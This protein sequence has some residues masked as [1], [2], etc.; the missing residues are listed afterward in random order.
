MKAITE[1][2]TSITLLDKNEIKRGGEGKILTIPELPDQVAKVYLNPNTS[3]LSIA[4]KEALS[5]LDTNYFVKPLELIYSDNK[6]K[7]EI[8]GFTMDFIPDD[9]V[10]LMV[11][12][13]KNFCVSNNIDYDFKTKLATRLI[14]ILEGAHQSDI[15]IGDLSGLNILVNMQ[16]AV[17]FLDVDS[18][19]TPVHTHSSV[20]FDEIR[21]YLYNGKVSKESDYFAL[22]I[23]IF[24]IFCHLHPFKGVHKIYKSIAERMINKIPVFVSDPDLI[25]PKCYEPIQEKMVQV[26]FEELFLEGKRF[27][28]KLQTIQT[29]QATQTKVILN[30]LQ[31]DQLILKELYTLDKGEVIQKSFFNTE[32]G[33]IA[34]NHKYMLWKVQAKGFADK[35]L[36]IPRG[37]FDHIFLGLKNIVATKGGKFFIHQ[38][39]QS[40]L[41]LKNIQFLEGMRFYQIQNILVIVDSAYMRWMYLDDVIQDQIR[42]EQQSVFGAGFDVFNGL[43]QNTGGV[44]YVFYHSG[45]TISTV[46]SSTQLLAVKIISTVGIAMI[47]NKQGNETSLQ[48]LLFS[49]DGLEM[50]L[51]QMN[52]HSLK[53]IAFQSINSKEGL[54]FEA[55]D[56]QLVVRSSKDFQVLQSIECPVISA[57]SQLYYTQAGIIATEQNFCYLINTKN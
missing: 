10:P 21:D 1:N 15:V 19:D 52:I 38:N 39:G 51:S 34:T 53:T 6:K 46:K 24:T 43:I 20:L 27:L 40:W 48:Y 33:Y 54:V 8:L 18:Y 32:T 7:K 41:E 26:Q 2:G 14:Q 30:V 13:N 37:N 28:L 47:E 35:F 36:E 56:N 55:E 29:L 22:A 4:Q 44:Q 50:K 5:A 25:I 17:R 31:A 12:F 3:H 23:L 11:F 16:G 57:E 49:V 42:I 45:K 9:F